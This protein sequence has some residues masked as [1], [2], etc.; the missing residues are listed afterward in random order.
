[1]ELIADTKLAK[2]DCV[3]VEY[4]IYGWPKIKQMAVA[5]KQH[6]HVHA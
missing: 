3:D 6:I 2:L 1:M 5:S 4:E